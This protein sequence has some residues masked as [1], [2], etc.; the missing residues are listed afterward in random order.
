MGRSLKGWSQEGRS[1]MGRS[2]M[3]RSPQQ[4]ESEGPVSASSDA[5]A[6]ADC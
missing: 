2:P 5:R 3:G 1:Q 4:A 6:G